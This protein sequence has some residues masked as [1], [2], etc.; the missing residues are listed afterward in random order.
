MLSGAGYGNYMLQM[1]RALNVNRVA[2]VVGFD[3]LSRGIAKDAEETLLRAKITLLT[4]LTI[5]RH[6]YQE[7]DYST[8][9]NSLKHVDARYI[10]LFA[11]SDVTTDF[12]YNAGPV[13]LIDEHYAWYGFNPPMPTSGNYTDPDY[14]PEMLAS[15]Q[16][17]GVMTPDKFANT[18]YYFRRSFFKL[19]ALQI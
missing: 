13:G 6:Y 8:L 3:S 19:L 9:Y 11:D 18:G 17:K 1:L 4:K 16:L 10:L 2:L 14:T 12:Y 5:T 15:G 7:K